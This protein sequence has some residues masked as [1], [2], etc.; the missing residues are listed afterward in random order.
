M[1][2]SDMAAACSKYPPLFPRRSNNNLS[3]PCP[4]KVS[5]AATTSFSVVA[6]NLLRKIYPVESS[7]IVAA[8]TL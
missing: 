8:P 6:E 3:M 1:N 5:I 7:I 2:W 4:S